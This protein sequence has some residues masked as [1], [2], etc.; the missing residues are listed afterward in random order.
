MGAIVI[1][2]VVIAG[3]GTS[4]MVTTMAIDE[5]KNQPHHFHINSTSPKKVIIKNSKGEKVEFYTNEDFT[6]YVKER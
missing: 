3:F 2:I 5:F 6:V 1:A 4:F